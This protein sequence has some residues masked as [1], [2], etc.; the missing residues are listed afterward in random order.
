MAH[1]N[2][3]AD[4]HSQRQRG[5][6]KCVRSKSN[7]LWCDW[8]ANAKVWFFANQ[9][10]R[11]MKNRTKQCKKRCNQMAHAYF[12]HWVTKNPLNWQQ[13]HTA[14]KALHWRVARV[15]GYVSVLR[16]AYIYLKASSASASSS[17]SKFS[18]NLKS[19][20]GLISVKSGKFSNL[21]SGNSSTPLRVLHAYLRRLH[22]ERAT[23]PLYWISFI[24][25]RISSYF[26]QCVDFI[27]VHTAH[28]IHAPLIHTHI[29]HY[30]YMLLF[31]FHCIPSIHH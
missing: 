9:S 2:T 27:Y 13:K 16:L 11:Q 31:D 8:F 23:T 20:N 30:V 14:E 26:S 22:S 12:K 15:Y 5:R 25:H 24:F 19:N 18:A 7:K 29:A 6:V 4:T 17:S 1:A 28:S 21:V 3:N 10:F